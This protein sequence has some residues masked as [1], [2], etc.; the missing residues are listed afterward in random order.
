[1]LFEN[2]GTLTVTGQGTMDATEGSNPFIV[3]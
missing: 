1:M 3:Y 2:R